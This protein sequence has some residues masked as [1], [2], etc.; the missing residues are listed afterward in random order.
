[1]VSARFREII[2]I[3]TRIKRRSPLLFWSLGARP[4]S[5]SFP[6]PRVYDVEGTSRTLGEHAGAEEWGRD[7]VFPESFGEVCGGRK[8]VVAAAPRSPW[9]RVWRNRGERRRCRP[10]G[11]ER[12]PRRAGARMCSGASLEPGENRRALLCSLVSLLT[13]WREKLAFLLCVFRRHA[14]RQSLSLSRLSIAFCVFNASIFNL[15]FFP[16]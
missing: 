11:L 14:H 10:G 7:G 12:L 1:M 9:K 3:R 4:P 6:F 13:F 8:V 16:S 2:H 5:S 15:F